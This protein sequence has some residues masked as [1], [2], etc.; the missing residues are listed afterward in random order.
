MLE[1]A[2]GALIQFSKVRGG[3]NSN[4]GAYLK[5]SAYL[6][7]HMQGNITECWLAETEGIFP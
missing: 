7:Y 1:L 2:P 4:G 6:I 5:G 3:A